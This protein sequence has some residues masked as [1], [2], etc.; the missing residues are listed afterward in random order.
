MTFDFLSADFGP[1][2]FGQNPLNQAGSMLLKGWL[3]GAE[4]YTLTPIL[5]PTGF[6]HVDANF[7]GIDALTVQPIPSSAFS[8]GYPAFLM[9][10][11]SYD[12]DGPDDLAPVTEPGTL[13]LLGSGG[14]ALLARRARRRV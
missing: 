9:D 4:I 3:N 14:A 12:I 5:A 7:T 6:T 2:S 10:N 8:T 1:W 13:F 11:F